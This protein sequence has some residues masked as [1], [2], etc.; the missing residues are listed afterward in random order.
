[1]TTSPTKTRRF[2]PWDSI[3]QQRTL[4]VSS[5]PLQTVIAIQPCF[6]LRPSDSRDRR[7]TRISFIQTSYQ[8]TLTKEILTWQRSMTLLTTNQRLPIRL[9][10]MGK[11]GR[12]FAIDSS[13]AL[14]IGLR[15]LR[16]TEAMFKLY[17]M[18]TTFRQRTLTLW[19]SFQVW[20]LSAMA[21][22]TLRSLWTIYYI[23]K[24]IFY[25]NI[26]IY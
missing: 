14:K 3:R 20:C 11:R 22:G 23:L 5:M 7:M 6:H 24:K 26:I 1:M 10:A 15:A 25:Y 18:Q 2:H 21:V 9:A 12:A 4:A 17:W 16:N 19:P 13:I 8:L